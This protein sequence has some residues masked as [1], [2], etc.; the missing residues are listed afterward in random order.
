MRHCRNFLLILITISFFI[1]ISACSKSEIEIDRSEDLNLPDEEADSVYI[2]A[3]NNNFIEYELT[4]SHI[5]KY[6]DENYVLADTIFMKSYNIDGSLK[7]TLS[8]NRAKI[9]DV[10]NL[11]IGEG[12]VVITSDNGIL[13]TPY[14]IWD[15]NTD[16]VRAMNGVTLIRE[17]HTLFGEQLKTDIYLKYIE[18]TKVSA[19]GKIDEETIDW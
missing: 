17:S 13:R 19:E 15:R 10:A 7:S 11:L 12:N 3:T 9:D 4:A 18:I 8:C 14:I 16:S 5:D 1:L 2:V 6:Y